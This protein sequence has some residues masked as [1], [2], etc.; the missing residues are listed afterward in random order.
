MAK[1]I[2]DEPTAGGAQGRQQAAQDVV[3][4]SEGAGPLHGPDRPHLLHHADQ[5]VIAPRVLTDAAAGLIRQVEAHLAQ[6]DLLLHLADRVGQRQQPL[7]RLTGRLGHAEPCCV[8][9]AGAGRQGRP[10]RA[11]PN[12]PACFDH[13]ARARRSSAWPCPCL[14]PQRLLVSTG[15]PA[16]GARQGL[17]QVELWIK[18]R[19][20]PQ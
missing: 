15:G 2:S 10:G 16:A 14:H 8:A 1:A 11:R 12:R 20:R 3:A 18:S 4:A 6:P 7:S 19:R 13:P 5:V 17:H 9:G